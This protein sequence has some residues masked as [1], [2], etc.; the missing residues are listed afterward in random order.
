MSLLR[1]ILL[2]LLFYWGIKLISGIVKLFR[3]DQGKVE[4]K[5][6]KKKPLDLS[7]HDVEDADFEEID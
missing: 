7:Q 1:L 6:Q 3:Q 2:G 5:P 4:G